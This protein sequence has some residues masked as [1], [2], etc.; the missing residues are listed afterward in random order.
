MLNR[1][2]TQLLAETD[3]IKI[4][5]V[6]MD[7]VDQLYQ[8]YSDPPAMRWVDDGQPIKYPDCIRWIEITLNN[9]ETRGY[10]L[11]AITLPDSGEIIGFCGLVHPHGQT[12][13]EIK[14]ALKRKYWGLGY[15]TESVSAMLEYGRNVHGLD[16][17]IATV[18]SENL[19]SQNV[20]EKS[21]LVFR[22]EL[23]EDDGSTT[24]VFVWQKRNATET[25]P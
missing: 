15:A 6:G 5:T 25:Q 16:Q 3:R 7:D 10:G 9:Y 19:A 23:K 17:I 8:V 11:S 18:A 13:P 12:E 20:L 14:Y 2:K 24:L 4:R 22:E 21:G 1:S